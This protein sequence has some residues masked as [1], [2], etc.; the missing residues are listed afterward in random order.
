MKNLHIS[1]TPY[2]NESRVIKQTESLISNSPINKVY[3][4]CLHSEGLKENE[5]QNQN[6]DIEIWRVKLRSRKLPKSPMF[7]LIKYFEFSFKVGLFAKNRKIDIVNIHLLGLLPIGVIIKY[8]TKSKLIYD[9]HE[10]ETEVEGLKGAKKHLAKVIEKLLIKKAD[11]TIV[12]GKEIEN[13]YKKEYQNIPIETIMNC[14]VYQKIKKTELLRQRLKIPNKYKIA[15]YQG[16]LSSA[17]GIN[18]LLEAFKSDDISDDYA[19]VF[20]GYGPL[21]SEVRR[22]SSISDN[23]YFMPAV[24]PDVILSFTCSA[25][26]GV[27]LIE[28]SN[29]SD[30]YC[31]PNKLFEFIMAGLPVFVSN[32]PE[33]AGVIHKYNIGKVLPHWSVLEVISLFNNTDFMGLSKGVKDNL[34]QASLV[35]N[36]EEQERLMI[37]AYNDHIFR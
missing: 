28:D 12:V 30:H 3:V 14:P 35:L 23:I 18:L 19:M 36:W 26:I 22:A 24:D 33:M 25:D 9:A 32:L 1:L 6:K 11:L 2:V 21:E 15:L 13:W 10:L 4:V 7:Q 8:L 34:K 37:N 31:L 16:G 17:R 20:M 5:Y 29:L 27:S